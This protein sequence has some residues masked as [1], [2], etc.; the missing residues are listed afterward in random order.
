MKTK[1]ITLKIPKDILNTVTQK[2][3]N[4]TGIRQ[5]I[6]YKYNPEITNAIE[7]Q[8]RIG[9]HMMAR[10]FLTK[11]W[12]YTIHPSRHPPRV[13][14]K[15][16]PLIWMEFFEPLW[17]NR[18]ALLH[19]TVNLYNQE[20]GDKLTAS[21]TWYCNNRHTVFAHRDIHLADNI[22]PTSLPTMPKE[23]KREWV[24][25]FEIAQAAYD[26]ERLTTTQ[27]TILKYMMPNPK[28]PQTTRQ[29]HSIKTPQHT[30]PQ[31]LKLTPTR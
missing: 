10:G 12:N 7:H 11:Q 14:V 28:L 4:H 30:S 23:Q 9:L 2:L 25:H 18:N 26:K 6:D 13:M 19:H 17:A 15:F 8:K 27:R 16:Q 3:S 31:L 1:G 5:G 20:D 21:N 22:D 29:K 24:H